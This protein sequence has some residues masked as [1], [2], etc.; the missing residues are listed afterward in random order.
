MFGF[1]NKFIVYIL[2]LYDS[3]Y[4]KYIFITVTLQVFKNRKMPGRMGGV[5][6]TVKNVWIYKIDPARNLMW[7]KGQVIFP[8]ITFFA[9]AFEIKVEGQEQSDIT[10][11]SRVI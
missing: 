6:R 8:L 1:S 11:D 5:Q 3:C 7:V 10:S 2:F 4:R 9:L